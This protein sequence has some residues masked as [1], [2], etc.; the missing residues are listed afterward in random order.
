MASKVGVALFETT[1][2]FDVVHVVSADDD[3][4]LHLGGDDDSS[5]DA[6][7]DRDITSEGA[8]FV[9]V[10]SFDGLGRGLDSQTDLFYV[11]HRLLAIISNGALTGHENGVLLL[12]RLFVLCENG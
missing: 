8:L 3:R 5:E 12:V 10:A 7:T 9:D 11:A 6:S 1:V 4:S 2:L